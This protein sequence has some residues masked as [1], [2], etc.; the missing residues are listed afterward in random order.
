M[1]EYLKTKKGKLILFGAAAAVILAV[2]IIILFCLPKEG[3]RT[4]EVSQIEGRAS[5]SNERNQDVTAY[6]G[7]ALFDGDTVSVF[8]ASRLAIEL[9]GDKHMMAESGTVFRLEASG[10]AGNDKTV[11]HL[12]QGSALVR[13]E[14][15]LGEDQSYIV[16]TP[17]STISVR[18]TVF[19]IL[20]T[21]DAEGKPMV[22]HHVLDGELEVTPTDENGQP[23]EES[24]LISQGFFA[25]VGNVDD[26]SRFL[27]NDDG[28]ITN[29][30]DAEDFKN[31]A[32]ILISYIE[33]GEVLIF[34]LEDLQALLPEYHIHTFEEVYAN[35]EYEHWYAASCEHIELFQKK[36]AHAW[37]DGIIINEPTEEQE[38]VCIYTCT[39]CGYER[40]EPI[41][42]LPKH[43][44]LFENDWTFDGAGHWHRA[45]CEHTE[46]KDRFSE[47]VFGEGTIE[48]DTAGVLTEVWIC[49][50]CGYGKYV[51]VTPIEHTHHYGEWQSE[52]HNDRE[53][54]RIC[55]CGETQSEVH[56]WDD[57][58][59][60]TRATHFTSGI[61][62]YTCTVCSH[63]KT[64]ETGKLS[65]HIYGNWKISDTD[66]NLHEKE[67]ACGYKKTEVHL[68]DEGTE[69]IPATH[70]QEGE[71]S[72]TC[73]IC[74]HI[75][76]EAIA[77]LLDHHYGD[78]QASE[79]DEHVHV[80]TCECG[81]VEEEGHD[82]YYEISEFAYY[83]KPGLR[84]HCCQVCG[85]Q[86][87]LLEYEFEEYLLDFSES[88]MPD[89]DMYNQNKMFIGGTFDYTKVKVIGI[90]MDTVCEYD[91]EG[92]LIGYDYGVV[93]NPDEYT[94]RFYES[95][96]DRENTALTE[97]DFT[98]RGSYII[99]YLPKNEFE[100]VPMRLLLVQPLEE[101]IWFALEMKTRADQ[102]NTE[103]VAGKISYA[104]AGLTSN[105]FGAFIWETYLDDV[106][107]SESSKIGLEALGMEDRESA[108]VYQL[109]IQTDMYSDNGIYPVRYIAHTGYGVIVFREGNQ[110]EI[111]TDL[112]KTYEMDESVT[113]IVILRDTIL[114]N[115]EYITALNENP[116][117]MDQLMEY[118]RYDIT[119]GFVIQPIFEK[120]DVILKIGTQNI[121]LT[122]EN[123]GLV[124]RNQF[125]GYEMIAEEVPLTEEAM[126]G[127][128]DVPYVYCLGEFSQM[129]IEYLRCHDETHIHDY[130]NE[131]ILRTIDN[132][133]LLNADGSMDI[134][135]ASKEFSSEHDMPHI[136]LFAGARYYGYVSISW[137][138]D[139]TDRYPVYRIFFY[140]PLLR[141]NTEY[142]ICF[143]VDLSSEEKDLSAV[144][145]CLP[146]LTS[147]DC[148]WGETE[149]EWFEL[150]FGD[151][152]MDLPTFDGRDDGGENPYET[153]GTNS[154]G[155]VYGTTGINGTGD[156]Y[157]T[158]DTGD[159]GI[160][161]ESLENQASLY[162]APSIL[163]AGSTVMT[164]TWCTYDRKRK[165]GKDENDSEEEG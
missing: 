90:Y 25:I 76:T 81:E 115:E 146:D 140:I 138:G 77:K 114:Q 98:K 11:I 109:R 132:R 1:K 89:F 122:F 24:R 70:L 78:W 163:L 13:I 160:S 49:T 161:T 63:T 99:E 26:V 154:T 9:D 106:K 74:R 103:Y 102:V 53:H 157:G 17:V 8:D 68:W 159:T 2:V 149:K 48:L 28:Q 57:G 43:Q 137:V 155:D 51:P 27:V 130:E 94:Y 59:I 133:A 22:S 144:Y 19:Y 14:N 30:I 45:V 52:R 119:G 50:V 60:T 150:Y 100:G 85:Y 34:D 31:L 84:Y 107:S 87:D 71:M 69:T 95:Y 33:D 129:E 134:I 148:F 80:R 7:M 121:G 131:I 101:N 118:L 97:I 135:F 145:D 55:E 20:I 83:Q 61:K 124:F 64:E 56:M 10:K 67:C 151:N 108:D 156:S 164:V 36:E 91:D 79:E 32:E 82:S 16:E 41:E 165:I 152:S 123:E 111:I 92:R 44:H 46:E 125:Y 12:E 162:A 18:G 39:V 120:T 54:I 65:A 136:N 47:H 72:Y 88:G 58:V 86:S 153:T 62:T 3:Y 37:N 73:E 6:E 128:V 29:P 21:K 15:K 116:N 105:D 127:A 117:S 141:E 93:L 112:S 23:T 5:V 75:K 35:N 110:P 4:I 38:G 113:Y 142:I 139:G 40:T 66:E 104:L 42:K 158:T 147:E 143:Y 96:G 126:F